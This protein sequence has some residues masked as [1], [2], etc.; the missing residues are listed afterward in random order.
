MMEYSN[1]IQNMRDVD[2]KKGIVSFYFANFETPD[3]NG[4]LV[5]NSSMSRTINAG[6]NRLKHY[7]NHDNGIVLGKIIELGK[8]EKGAYAVSQL[9]KSDEGRNILIQYDEGLI[10]EH[11][12]GWQMLKSHKEGEIEVAE[13]VRIWEVSSMT[14]W[15][16]HSETPMINLNSHQ[17]EL[18]KEFQAM[19]V[20]NKEL[21]E[22]LQNQDK[23]EIITILNDISARLPMTDKEYQASQQSEI[24]EVISLI[25][26]KY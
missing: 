4:R 12:F 23:K 11:S 24:N 7:K 5:T 10:N 6:G 19:S 16:A 2:T 15:G 18:V 25:N 21:L 26:T 17:S 3:S 22:L 9:S 1:L 8:D 20:V 14:G 13:E